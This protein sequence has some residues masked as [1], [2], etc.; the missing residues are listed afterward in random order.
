MLSALGDDDQMP[1]ES[2]RVLRFGC[3][4][5]DVQLDVLAY[6]TDYEINS[7]KL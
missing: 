7:F 5:L 2:G 6:K 3:S 1:F 4:I